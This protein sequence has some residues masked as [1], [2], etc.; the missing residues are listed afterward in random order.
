MDDLIYFLAALDAEHRITAPPVLLR[1]LVL[2]ASGKGDAPLI[3]F[4]ERQSIE[5]SEVRARLVKTGRAIDSLRKGSQPQPFTNPFLEA[6]YTLWAEAL[7]EGTVVESEPDCVVIGRDREMGEIENKVLN[8]ESRL[9]AITGIGGIGK[10]VLLGA[11]AKKLRSNRRVAYLSCTT[12]I[13]KA[14]FTDKLK[15]ALQIETDSDVES[16]VRRTLHE[17]PTVLILDRI[18][19]LDFIEQELKSLIAS[20]E[21][22]SIVTSCRALSENSAIDNFELKPF[23]L[24][25]ESPNS[26]A[27]SLFTRLAK[28]WL[29]KIEDHRAAI[30]QLCR[31]TQG[32]PLA[33]AISAGCLRTQEIGNLSHQLAEAT[34]RQA[35]SG[36][37]VHSSVDG[38]FRMLADQ[39]QSALRALSNFSGPFLYDDGRIVSDLNDEDFSSS[40]IRLHQCA[41]IASVSHEGRQGYQVA[42]SVI[43]YLG[44]PKLG[45]PT[46]DRFV[47]LFAHRA[48]SIGQAM[49]ADRWVAGT[50]ELLSNQAQLRKASRLA[51]ESGDGNEIQTFADG[52]CRTYFESGR[53]ADFEA[54]C[55]AAIGLRR[56]ELSIRML[57]LR[58]ALASIK[59]DNRT[60]RDLWGQRLAIANKIGDFEAGADTLTDLAWQAFEEGNHEE[61]YDY[62]EQS[63]ALCREHGLIELEAT[64]QIIR[65]QMHLEAGDEAEARAWIDKTNVSLESCRDLKMLPFVYQGLARSY[66]KLGETELAISTLRTQLKLVSEGHRVIHSAR[67]L[68]SLAS[69]Y[70]RKGEVSL[71]LECL[72]SAIDALN[73]YQTRD[74]GR[75]RTR[76]AEL[77][78]ANQIAE[79]DPRLQATPGGWMQ[80]AKR[81]SS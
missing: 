58:G 32:V 5:R 13:S 16:A 57:G 80:L 81:L 40:L 48:A 6:V 62:L 39:D 51:I 74:L 72:V 28:P 42:D 24:S 18:D 77:C 75:C 1:D 14:D 68:A 56:E 20:G 65:A 17:V 46:T 79:T 12:V 25:D 53:L 26:P 30:I 8:G 69:L 21:N 11:L 63:E 44:E 70:E 3:D 71:A 41:L 33:I 76:L 73:E 38:C 19:G 22:L 23:D 67:T 47:S 54:L 78:E 36:G 60:C 10:T 43:E 4:V 34:T 7:G 9:L 50:T 55:D 49:A 61:A 29:E 35:Y 2:Y 15:N 52:L 64:A 45:E 37:V 66:D 31:L 27:I 59:Q